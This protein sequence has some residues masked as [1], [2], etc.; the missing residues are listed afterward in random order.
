MQRVDEA[1]KRGPHK[2]CLEHTGCNP[3][4][5]RSHP[6]GSEQ[7]SLVFVL[8]DFHHAT[9][10]HSQKKLCTLEGTIFPS[11]LCIHLTLLDSTCPQMSTHPVTPPFFWPMADTAQLLE[12]QFSHLEAQRCGFPSK[13][14]FYATIVSTESKYREAGCA[15][16]AATAAT[17]ERGVD[18]GA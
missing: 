6:F 2:S 7:G 10:A 8:R 1:L 11:G 9:L 5:C 3:T 15:G 4:E 14:S 17:R 18:Y 16:G 12:R 13:A